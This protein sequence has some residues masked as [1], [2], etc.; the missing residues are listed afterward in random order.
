MRAFQSLTNVHLENKNSSWS[1]PARI[2]E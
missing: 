2:S 1:W